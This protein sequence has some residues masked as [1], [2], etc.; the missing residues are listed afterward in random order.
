MNRLLSKTLSDENMLVPTKS[1]SGRVYMCSLMRLVFWCYLGDSCKCGKACRRDRYASVS[2]K[3]YFDLLF[4]SFV[5]GRRWEGAQGSRRWGFSETHSELNTWEVYLWR[6]RRETP[7]MVKSLKGSGVAGCHGHSSQPQMQHLPTLFHCHSG[8]L[9]R[10][11]TQ[12]GGVARKLVCEVWQRHPVAVRLQ[13]LNRAFAFEFV[14]WRWSRDVGAED[15]FFG[16]RGPRELKG[17]ELVGLRLKQTVHPQDFVIFSAHRDSVTLCWDQ[18]NWD[19]KKHKTH[20]RGKEMCTYSRRLFFHT[21][22]PP[23]TPYTS[24]DLSMMKTH[25]SNCNGNE[26]L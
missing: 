2:A 20:Q 10:Q 26:T 19:K 14:I 12:E 5:S 24:S 17:V 9:S 22:S 21:C 1:H 4:F 16:T 8:C 11:S 25:P 23:R 7:K 13:F 15:G 3:A 6:K 18:Q